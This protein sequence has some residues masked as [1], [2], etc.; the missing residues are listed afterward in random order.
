[1]ACVES[2]ERQA[3]DAE[4]VE[5]AA[6][7]TV[8]VTRQHNEDCRRLLTLLGVP[9]IEVRAVCPSRTPHRP[10]TT[11]TG[12]DGHWRTARKGTLAQAGGAPPQ[13]TS[14][15]QHTHNVA[16]AIISVRCQTNTATRDCCS[17]QARPHARKRKHVGGDACL[18][19]TAVPKG[20]SAQRPTT[21]AKAAKQA[22]RRQ[23]HQHEF[24][25]MGYVKEEHTLVHGLSAFLRAKVEFD[26]RGR[27]EFPQ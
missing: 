10:V 26:K 1:M 19:R 8:K 23:E 9:V 20:L 14:P 16:A 12:R 13:V 18:T 11:R 7:K 25:C 3:G 5:K 21:G 24:V 2:V 4:A 22:S 15:T 6:K 17:F 27:S